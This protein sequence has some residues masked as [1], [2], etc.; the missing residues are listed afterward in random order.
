MTDFTFFTHGGDGWLCIQA[1]QQLQLAHGKVAEQ[2]QR[3]GVGIELFGIPLG[4]QQQAAQMIIT[5]VQWQ[6]KQA[7]PAAVGLG[8]KG[9]GV[10]A[11][12][13]RIDV[14]Y[15]VLKQAV[16]QQLLIFIVARQGRFAPDQRLTVKPLGAQGEL[17][18][19]LVEQVELC[20]W[21]MAQVSRG[22]DQLLLQGTAIAAGRQRTE[23]SQ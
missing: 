4:D 2:T 23:P 10:Q 11:A 16:L 3:V 20:Q 17:G 13:E 5:V 9:R 1:L 18:L 12:V 21:A 6:A 14:Q 7:A 8:Q 15:L 22:R 19:G